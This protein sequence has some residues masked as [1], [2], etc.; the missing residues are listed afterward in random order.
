[1]IMSRMTATSAFLERMACIEGDCC[2]E[3]LSE[4]SDKSIYDENVVFSTSQLT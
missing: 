4:R 2:D 3:Y 1:M